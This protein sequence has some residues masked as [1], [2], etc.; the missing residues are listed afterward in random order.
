MDNVIFLDFQAKTK[1]KVPSIQLPRSKQSIFAKSK[2]GQNIIDIRPKIKEDRRE[3]RRTIISGLM[4]A[5]I[6]AP[7]IGLIRP[8]DVHLYD[9]SKTGISF[10]LHK[11]YG[12]KKDEKLGMRFYVNHIDFFKLNILITGHPRSIEEI[13]PFCRYGAKFQQPDEYSQNIIK[14]LVN[15][16]ESVSH[17]LHKDRGEVLFSNI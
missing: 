10:D 1:I 16:I 3:K 4:N 17:I 15:F 9:I 13:D 7:S 12:L 2:T 14:N 8:T 6:I 5:A 11:K